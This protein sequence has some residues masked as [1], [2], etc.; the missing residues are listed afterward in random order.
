MFVAFVV[1]EGER[2]AKAA[3]S[4]VLETTTVGDVTLIK[5]YKTE[6]LRTMFPFEVLFQTREEAAAWAADQIDATAAV[7]MAQAS[8]LRQ[9]APVPV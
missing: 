2:G 4:E 3:I 5:C 7:L 1:H 6:K 9:T 8:Q